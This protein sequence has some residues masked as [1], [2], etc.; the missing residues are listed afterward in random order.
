MRSSQGRLVV[1]EVQSKERKRRPS[2]PF[3]TSTLQQEAARKLGFS[4]SRTM[5]LAQGLYEGVALG[6]E[7]TVGLI[8]YMR[9]DSLNLAMD[10]IGEIRQ[11]LLDPNGIYRLFV[12]IARTRDDERGRVFSARL[13]ALL[14]DERTW[15]GRKRTRT[16]PTPADDQGGAR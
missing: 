13:C 16:P 5:R 7:G 6:S 15:N 12:A 10:A 14:R 3:T 9:T 8:T 11:L 4:T 1:S 2:P